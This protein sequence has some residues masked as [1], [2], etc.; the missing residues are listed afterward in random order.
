[1]KTIVAD[2]EPHKLSS[3]CAQFTKFFRSAVKPGCPI[4]GTSLSLCQGWETTNPLARKRRLPHRRWPAAPSMERPYR[5][6]GGKPR[7]P[8]VPTSTN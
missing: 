2:L 8:T 5:A 1:M 7:T 3:S 4:L 6:M